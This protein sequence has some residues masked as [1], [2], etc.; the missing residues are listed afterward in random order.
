MPA[1]RE[2]LRD[3]LRPGLDRRSN[4][5]ILRHGD[6][7]SLP[8]LQDSEN[9]WRPGLRDVVVGTPSTR[10]T[11]IQ[12][13]I[14]GKWGVRRSNIVAL[15][16]FVGREPHKDGNGPLSCEETVPTNQ[17]LKSAAWVDGC[18]A[19]RFAG[20]RAEKAAEL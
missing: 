5:L 13:M 9:Y 11:R 3:L 1:R 6:L 14:N 15:P 2:N 10:S 16:N 20:W 19:W 4:S 12:V 8:P 17:C 18:S 7:I